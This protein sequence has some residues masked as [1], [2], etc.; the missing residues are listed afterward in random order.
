[1]SQVEIG[2]R[3]NVETGNSSKSIKELKE[4]IKASS[5]AMEKA[6]IGSKEYKEASEKLKESQKELAGATKNASASVGDMSK[7]LD[8]AMPGFGG[9][10][11]GAQGLLKSFWALVANPIGIVITALVGAVLALKAAFTSSE[12]GQNKWAKIMSMIGAIVG[13]VTD[14]LATLGEKLIS[15]FENPQKA[16]ESFAKAIKDNIVNRFT[17]L[18]ELLP[19]VG[20][21][22]GQLFELDF[23][24]AAKTA[25]DAVGKVALGVENVTDKVG[26]AVNATKEWAAE[27]AKEAKL[28]GE[29]ADMRAKAQKIDR[30]L[31]VERSKK[32][33]EIAELKLKSREIDEYTASE[34]KKFLQQAQDLE[35]GLLAKEKTS[36]QL[37]Y[38]AQKLENTFSRTN[39]ENKQKEA[40]AEADLNNIT[41]RRLNQQKATQRELNRTNKEIARG[42]AESAKEAAENDKNIRENLAAFNEKLL[43]ITQANE[44]ALI[45][46]QTERKIRALEFELLNEKALIQKD[47]EEKKISSA[48]RSSLLVE[49]EKGNALAV[50]AI[51]DEAAK[52]ALDKRIK[53]GQEEVKILADQNKKRKELALKEADQALGQGGFDQQREALQK[54]FELQQGYFLMEQMAAMGNAERLKEIDLERVAAERENSKAR[55]DIDKLE[56][57]QK[58]NALDLYAGALSAVGDLAGKQTALGKGLALAETAINTYSAAQKAYASQLVVGDP[59]SIVRA[60]IAGA[61]AIIA[62]LAKVKAIVAV[63]VPGAGGGGVPSV[64]TSAPGASAAPV[65]QLTQLDQNSINQI[66][67]QA[68]RAY[69]VTQDVNSDQEKIARINRAARLV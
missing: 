42:N 25:A 69:V 62:G 11:A 68:V 9:V 31:T 4:E 43:K 51:K 22:I 7:S 48:Q 44:L 60:K 53:N 19:A 63:K 18:L 8:R 58:L 13:N 59:T 61:T 20:K 41:A 14:L 49:I 15:V 57:E 65:A 37:K 34:R 39:I 1:M 6:K 23:S 12:E 36:L 26:D 45:A 33:S 55:T 2:A 32:E 54:K 38:D 64:N 21:A 16:I 27:N 50:Q 29:V 47:F 35:D 66:G 28:A 52:T 5:A 30:D 17:G 67:N 46:D 3:I 10:I 40:Q 24:G 56:K